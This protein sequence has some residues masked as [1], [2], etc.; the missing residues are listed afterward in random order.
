M[1]VGAMTRPIRGSNGSNRRKQHVYEFY[2]TFSFREK[3]Q[4]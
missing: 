2:Y 3:K 4:V 1:D